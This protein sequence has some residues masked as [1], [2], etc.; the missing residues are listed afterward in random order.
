MLQDIS[1][2]KSPIR[3]TQQGL[4]DSFLQELFFIAEL[5]WSVVG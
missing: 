5:Q 4:V 3:K 1:D 2:Q